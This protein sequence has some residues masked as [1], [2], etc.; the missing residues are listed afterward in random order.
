MGNAQA[1]AE[2]TVPWVVEPIVL[3]DVAL[4]LVHILATVAARVLA[5]Q[6][7]ILRV[8][9]LAMINVPQFVLDYVLLEDVTPHAAIIA[10]GS[11]LR[12]AEEILSQP[13]AIIV[14]EAPVPTSV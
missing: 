8:K 9:K 14:V 6:R 13:P 5:T 1:G 3:V 10:R 7:V 2:W 4:V 11:A 12:N